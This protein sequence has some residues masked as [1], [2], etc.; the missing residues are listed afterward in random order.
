MEEL[1]PEFLST[2]AQV[3]A[4]FMGFALL[5]PVFQTV[6]SGQTFAGERYISTKYFFIK[7]LLLLLFPLLVLSYP[8]IFS[9]FLLRLDANSVVYFTITDYYKFGSLIFGFVILSYYGWISKWSKL[10]G[11]KYFRKSKIEIS[12]LFRF[13]VNLLP[14]LF[15]FICLVMWVSLLPPFLL[16]LHNLKLILIFLVFTGFLSILRNVGVEI[17]KGILFKKTEISCEFGNAKL[18]FVK[19][20]EEAEKERMK[21]INKI[22][23]F[24]QKYKNNDKLKKELEEL[25]RSVGYYEGEIENLRRLLRN[26]HNNGI[27]DLYDKLCNENMVTL[28]KFSE[29]ERRRIDGERRIEEFEVGTIVVLNVLKRKYPE[30]EYGVRWDD[31]S[32]QG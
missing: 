13:A 5:T 18:R 3:S 12:D 19:K 7:W 2:I 32:D 6:A 20:V 29:F 15:I 22:N 14:V 26:K 27:E 10:K 25:K 21:L 8:L 9:L 11:W 1:S 24:L 4:T 17:N 16:H 28:E 30:N 31:E 23:S